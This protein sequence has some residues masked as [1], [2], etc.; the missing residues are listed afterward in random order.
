MDDFA[1]EKHQWMSSGPNLS[2]LIVQ[3][4]TKGKR[5]KCWS[6]VQVEVKNLPIDQTTENS[7]KC[8]D[9]FASNGSAVIV[10]G[11]AT[12]EWAQILDLAL[13]LMDENEV[14]V[15]RAKTRS[16]S[17]IKFQLHLIKIISVSP[18]LHMWSVPEIHQKTKQLKEQG[19]SLYKT[20]NTVEAFHVFSKSLKLVLPLEVRLNRKIAQIEEATE[21]EKHQKSECTQLIEMISN[22]M[23]ACQLDQ[24]NYVHTIYLCDQVLKRNP[25][26]VKAIYRKASA[27]KGDIFLDYFG[28]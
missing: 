7:L 28:Y 11:F 17:N 4:G 9:Y 16:N 2:K 21:N 19:I 20:K 14:S 18:P 26:N 3:F 1:N 25:S 13:Q 24:K 22:N 27:H 15:F 12:N 23:A 6:Q 8:P 10:I 5:P